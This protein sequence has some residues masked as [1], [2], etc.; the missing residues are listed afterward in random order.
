ML[1]SLRYWGTGGER[2]DYGK[3]LYFCSMQQQR[4][5]NVNE[6]AEYR[7]IIKEEPKFDTVSGK[8]RRK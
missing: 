1:I 7:H 3:C 5:A 2:N 4:K 6:K 8:K